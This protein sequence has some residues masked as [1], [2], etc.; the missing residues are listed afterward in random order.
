MFCLRRKLKSNSVTIHK[1][2]IVAIFIAELTFLIGINRTEDQVN[3][4]LKQLYFRFCSWIYFS[5]TFPV[6]VISP[7]SYNLTTVVF[8]FSQRI[9]RLIAIVLHYFFCASFSWMFVEGLHMYRRLREKRNIDTG[10]MSFYYFMGWG[11]S[12][13]VLHIEVSPYSVGIDVAF[14]TVFNP[15]AGIYVEKCFG[16]WRFSHA[17][18]MLI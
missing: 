4:S 12:R 13:Y 2:L 15:V 16:K 3:V 1:N 8:Y 10:K 14:N 7:I 18:F 11:K 6:R 9:C 17:R 5:T